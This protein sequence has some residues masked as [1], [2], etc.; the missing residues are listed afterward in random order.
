V[1]GGSIAVVGA[2]RVGSAI[3]AALRA[4]GAEVQ[5]PLGRGATGA[6]AS[7]VLLA[8]PDAEIGAAAAAL[9]TEG[10]VGH[11]SGATSLD[12][13]APH[14]AL[15]IHPLL[16]I[17]GPEASFRDV[18]AAVAGSTPHALTTAETLATT[19]GMHPF[20]VDEVDRAAYHAAASIASNFLVTLEAFAEDLAATAGVDRDALVPL[21]RATV[22]NWSDHGPAHA[23]TGPIV[24]GDDATVARQRAALASGCRS[25]W[26]C[27]TR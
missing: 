12:P 18:P 13:L 14:E 6:G 5:G 23:L 11:F 17:T 1:L 25:A 2:G 26:R 19:L 7:I 22:Q 15:S 10:L 20:R 24:R 21:V 16:A 27:S 4:S 3:A 9:A 8:V